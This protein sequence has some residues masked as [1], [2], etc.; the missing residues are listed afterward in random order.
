MGAKTKH[1]PTGRAILRSRME[2]LACRAGI[3]LLR[4][5]VRAGQKPRS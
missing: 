1:D 5:R 4:A 2:W 3:G